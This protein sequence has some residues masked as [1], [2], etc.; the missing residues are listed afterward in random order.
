MKA[1]TL[2]STKLQRP[3]VGP[4][5]VSRTRLIARLEN[6]RYRKVTLISAPAG[7]GKTILASSWQETCD[8]PGAW[9]SLDENDND[10]GVFVH[11]FISAIQT[12]FPESLAETEALLNGQKLPTV[13][14]VSTYLV[15]EVASVSQPFT[16]VFDDFHVILNQKINRLIDTLI[17]YLPSTLHLVL[18]TRRDPPLDIVNLRAKNQITEIRLAELRFD[19]DEALQYLDSKLDDS[20]TPDFAYEL[21]QRT[22]GWPVGLRL[23]GMAWRYQVDQD[24]FLQKLQGTN[25]YIMNYLVSEVLSLQSE[26][27]QTFLLKT[28]LLDRF[29][30]PLCDALFA[31]EDSDPTISSQEIINHILHDNLFLIS[32]DN[33]DQWFRY[34]HL[35]Q[36]LLRYQLHSV[37]SEK[38]IS[39]LHIQASFWLEEQGFIEEA[40]DHASKADDMDRAAQIVA[41]AR[42]GLMNET[43]WQ[44]LESLLSRFRPD[45]VDQYPDLQMARIWLIY[46][47]YQW[48]K[49]PAAIDRLEKQI[50]QGWADSANFDY[51]SGEISALRSLLLYFAL[52]TAGVVINSENALKLTAPELWSARILARLMLAGTQLLAGDLAS[53]Y[54]TIY[55]SFDD[56]PSQSD[57]LKAIV[58]VTACFIAWI[59][60]DMRTLRQNAAQVIHLSQNPRSPGMLGYGHYFSGILAY[61]RDD[62]LAAERHFAYVVQ[63]PYSTYDD[64][65]TYSA[66][67][68]A[69]TYQAQCREQEA[70]DTVD[71]ALAY[72]LATGNTELLSV[73]YAFQA[74]LSL[75]QGQLS[76]ANQWAERFEPLLPLSPMTQIYT[77]HM[78]M[79]KVWL[80]INTASSR[81][82]ATNLLAQLKEFLEFT[83]NS[84]FL[85]KTLALQ[86]ML[87]Q[88]NGD[89][90]AALDTLEQAI[91][92]AMPGNLIRLFVDLGP[93]MGN[94]LYKLPAKGPEM[95]AYKENI[96]AAMASLTSQQSSGLSENSGSQPLGKPLT[97]REMDVLVLL[98]QRQTDKE[99]AERLVISFYTVRTHAR[100]IYSKLGV[101]NRRQATIRAQKLGLISP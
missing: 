58:L 31:A 23:A 36:D 98:S 101:N 67:G 92:L 95:A 84:I 45:T 66:C 17:R 1:D 24:R 35:F 80:A 51:L 26:S 46:Q 40:L 71:A 69:L 81:E 13:D 14:I 85:I 16:L 41:R 47:Q 79:V 56:E 88:L 48:T 93:S 15:N 10:L 74:E 12:I 18:I 91:V 9:L 89:E 59:A 65:F 28:S 25:R 21:F 94:L 33:N 99:I 50:S 97:D 4:N 38:S 54:T 32:I 63:R 75:R 11:Y 76:A 78:T 61:H 55:T 29:N 30:A 6:G 72:L 100:N 70:R 5:I 53:A 44:R 34:H 90:K 87:H 39:Q 2:I 73:L 42:Y 60:A 8:C 96:L 49:L 62:L 64:S 83:H 86:T 3:V 19:E 20:I 57:S 7:Y 68:L 52:D 82:N 37:F 22:E 77:P 27:V 43:Q